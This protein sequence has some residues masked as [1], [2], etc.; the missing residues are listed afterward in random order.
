MFGKKKK[1][2]SGELPD[3]SVDR[4]SV[5]TMDD[6]RRPQ[7]TFPVDAENDDIHGLPSFP[8]SP[9]RRG[10]SQSMIKSA[11]ETPDSREDLPALP[12]DDESES[13]MPK[14]GPRLVELE[15]WKPSLPQAMSMSEP[16][17]SPPQMPRQMPRQSS[18][19]MPSQAMKPEI[20]VNRPVFIKLDKFKDAR[21]S[22]AAITEKVTHLDEL[23]KMIKEVKAK[24]NAEIEHWEEEIEKIKSR[25]GSVNSELFEN[26][27]R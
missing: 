5:P 9:M 11:V 10:F 12:D 22:L 25:I 3:L 20:E 7:M 17:R 26:A 4:A 15:E 27:T 1:S 8:D 16:A 21:E 6:Y 24:E 18:R 23:L 19:Q 13:T 2:D 14:K